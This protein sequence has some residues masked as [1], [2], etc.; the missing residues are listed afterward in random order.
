MIS[1]KIIQDSIC[2]DSRLTTFIVTF[3]RFILA[4][5]NTHRAFSRNYASSRAVP[6]RKRIEQVERNCLVPLHWH[7]ECSGMQGYV[8]LDPNEILAANSIWRGAGLQAA[9]SA[10]KLMELGVHKQIVNRLLEPFIEVTGLIT[11]TQAGLENFF[12]LRA[13]DAAEP[14][15]QILA[16][17]MLNAYNNHSPFQLWPGDWHIPFG[18]SMSENISIQSRIRRAVARCARISYNNFDG[19]DDVHKDFEL[20]DKLVANGHWSAFEHIAQ[21]EN[22]VYTTERYIPSN[23]EWPWLQL[24]KTYTNECRKDARVLEYVTTE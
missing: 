9:E 21:V 5:V 14:H 15:M 19:S 4:E 10:R 7:R 2:Q 24:R 1:A 8:N 12:A 17:E 3:P 18:D 13:N 20:H 16:N 22:E 11:S 6:V 23:F